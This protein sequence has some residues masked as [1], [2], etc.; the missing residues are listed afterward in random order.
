LIIFT[1]TIGLVQPHSVIGILEQSPASSIKDQNIISLNATD[2]IFD[3]NITK[4]LGSKN[5]SSSPFRSN[6]GPG[7]DQGFLNE[8]GNVT[9]NQTYLS[10]HL[11]DELIQSTG[12]GTFE[13]PD[14]QS[15]AG[16]LLL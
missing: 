4:D 12:N 16:C 6:R 2:G 1:I 11:T 9:S 3:A 15:I 14:G 7:D 10:T 13:T 5:I 8:V